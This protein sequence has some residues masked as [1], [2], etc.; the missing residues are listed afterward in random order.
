MKLSRRAYGPVS[1]PLS[2][3]LVTGGVSLCWLASSI[4]CLD[5]TDTLS[6]CS[7]TAGFVTKVAVFMMVISA[8]AAVFVLHRLVRI[9]A[10]RQ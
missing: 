1:G 8:A 10:Q 3:L 6:A 7:P 2:I 5:G 9:V 4:R